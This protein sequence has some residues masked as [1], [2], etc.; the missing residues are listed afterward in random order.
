MGFKK[1]V[2]QVSPTGMLSWSGFRPLKHSFI[3]HFHIFVY[4]FFIVNPAIAFS[5]IQVTLA[6]KEQKNVLIK[7]KIKMDL[8]LIILT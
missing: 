7:I 2:D 3:M 8:E 1:V 6:S 5:P 4:R